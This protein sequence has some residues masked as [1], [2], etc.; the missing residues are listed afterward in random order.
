[1]THH[2][3]SRPTSIATRQGMF[4]LYLVCFMHQVELYSSARPNEECLDILNT[5]YHQ[6]MPY[7]AAH[8][9]V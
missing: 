7:L 9:S 3:Q 5:Y 1:M 2:W 8:I 4:S 6:K